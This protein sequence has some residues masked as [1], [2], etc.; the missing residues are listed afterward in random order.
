MWFAQKAHECLVGQVP[1]LHDGILKD[2]R[3]PPRLE[4]GRPFDHAYCDNLGVGRTRAAA[5]V[6]ARKEVS[7]QAR[8]AGL[9]AHEETGALVTTKTL[10]V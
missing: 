5:A 8:L 6:V 4:G 7:A 3:P 2:R 9:R 10:G 1:F